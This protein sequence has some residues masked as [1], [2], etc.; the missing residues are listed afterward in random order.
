MAKC[1]NDDER[2]QLLMDA[3]IRRGSPKPLQG[4]AVR[5]LVKYPTEAAVKFLFEIYETGRE[6]KRDDL[7]REAEEALKRLKKIPQ[8]VHRYRRV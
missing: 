6:T 4:W 5:T 7:G 2:A 3:A 8:E 1:E